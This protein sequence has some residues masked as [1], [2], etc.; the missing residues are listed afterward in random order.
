MSYKV[1]DPWYQ[2]YKNV[3]G[4]NRKE[5]IK[6]ES[7]IKYKIDDILLVRM[8][9]VAIGKKPSRTNVI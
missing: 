1:Y 8:L 4:Y 2:V 3:K 7:H 9:R 6:Y 5:T